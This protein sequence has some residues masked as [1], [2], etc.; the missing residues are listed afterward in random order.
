MSYGG[1]KGQWASSRAGAHRLLGERR[2]LGLGS[3]LALMFLAPA[4][5]GWPPPLGLLTCA[6]I[7]FSKPVPSH[8]IACI[9]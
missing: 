7:L 3:R 9:Y 5:W 8:P 1:C 4:P 6:L 2:P